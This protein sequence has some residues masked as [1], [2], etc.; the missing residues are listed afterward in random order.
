MAKKPAVPADEKLE[1]QEL[2]I[3]DVLKAL[4]RKDYG[5][6]DRLSEVQQKKFVPYI[7]IQWMSMVDAGKDIQRYYVLSTEYN[8]NKYL[9]NEYIQKHPKLQWLMLCASSPGVGTQFHKWIPNISPKVSM[10]EVAPKLADIKE[11]YK[12]LYPK[13]DSDDISAVSQAFVDDNK[14]KAKLAS[15]YPTLKLTDIETLNQVITDE[16]IQQYEKDLGN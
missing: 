16:E 13:A 5:Y 4:D 11:Y 14:R 8:A 9:F 6:Y 10:L 3:F 7:I 15:L 12:K 2:N 1:N